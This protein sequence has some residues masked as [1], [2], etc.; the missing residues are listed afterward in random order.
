[1]GPGVVALLPPDGLNAFGRLRRSLV[2]IPGL[3]SSA[4]EVEIL[5]SFRERMFQFHRLAHL[6]E[7]SLR[8]WV[9]RLAIDLR[10]TEDRVLLN[11]S[12][13]ILV[14]AL[15]VVDDRDRVA[16]VV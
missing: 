16:E 9:D 12:K 1:M 15:G 13:I 6:S 4:A 2:A 8:Q 14:R 7:E 11:P 10:A 5:M 3:L